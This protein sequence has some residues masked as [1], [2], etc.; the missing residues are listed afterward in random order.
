MS[1]FYRLRKNNMKETK[2]FGKWYG[3]AVH[4]DVVNTSKLAVIMQENCT[5]KHSD[6][7]AVLTELVTTMKKELLDSKRVKINGLGS[8]KV[9]FSSKGADSAKEYSAK[10]CVKRFRILFQP[11]VSTDEYGRRTHELLRGAKAQE[12]PKNDVDKGDGTEQTPADGDDP[13][14]P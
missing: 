8:F 6:I 4:T 14:N 10:D 9:S 1:I 5:V 11:E 3:K 2:M 7:L 12:L 13:Q